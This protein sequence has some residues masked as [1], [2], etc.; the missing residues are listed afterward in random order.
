M[1]LGDRAIPRIAQKPQE[2]GDKLLSVSGPKQGERQEGQVEDC[3]LHQI[4]PQDQE[5]NC[6]EGG[7]A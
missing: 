6:R 2:G 4:V 1:L 3:G 5:D 7:E